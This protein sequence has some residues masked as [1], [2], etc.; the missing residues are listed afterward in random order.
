MKPTRIMRVTNIISLAIAVILLAG[1][2]LVAIG[3]V[4]AFLI[5]PERFSTG[6][7]L[8]DLFVYI[9]WAAAIILFLAAVSPYWGVLFLTAN[10]G[11]HLH[12]RCIRTPDDPRNFRRMLTDSIIKI[13]AALVLSGYTIFLSWLISGKLDP[14]QFLELNLELNPE[15][16]PGLIPIGLPIF[17]VGILLPSVY[18][19]F[20]ILRQH[21]K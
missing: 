19:L 5:N 13:A 9:L 12:D 14:E 7:E 6:N 4:V 20:L 17:L 10:I 11:L 2:I 18:N 3:I 15:Q 8:L 16:V 1:V 21:K